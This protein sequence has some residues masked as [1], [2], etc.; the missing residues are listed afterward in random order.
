[1][2]QFREDLAGLDYKIILPLK[3]LIVIRQKM[4]K[5]LISG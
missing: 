3:G 5:G 4:D 1:M 2:L